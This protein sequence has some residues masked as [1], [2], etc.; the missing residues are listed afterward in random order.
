MAKSKK[1]EVVEEVEEEEAE[2]EEEELEADDDDAEDNKK[3]KKVEITF[4]S[5]E[6]A[7][8]EKIKSYKEYKD[9]LK[10]YETVDKIF[11]KMM[12]KELKS[13]SKRKNNSSDTPKA[14]S[15][16][17][18][19]KPVPEAFKK[20]F[21]SKLKKNAE[22]MKEYPELNINEDQP[23]TIITKLVHAYLRNK[24]LYKKKD[25]GSYNKRVMAPDAALTTLLRIQDDEELTFENVQK[26][27][28]RI[29]AGDADDEE[30][31]EEE[32]AP[33]KVKSKSQTK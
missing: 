32:V 6:D 5:L 2:V 7:K 11:Q 23:R 22:I 8:A 28:S 16:F 15:G 10:H 29:Y 14:P 9:A 20:F 4:E 27:I 13:K 25:D 31:D 33:V 3:K 18:A 19:N 17:T 24:N 1:Q 21:E 12:D 30:E 26:Y